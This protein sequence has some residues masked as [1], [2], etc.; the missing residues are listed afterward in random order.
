MDY[1]PK[2]AHRHNFNRELICIEYPG[3]VVNPE[4]MMDTLGGIRDISATFE[5]GRRRLELRFRPE[6]MYAKPVFG[7]AM[8]ASAMALKIVVRRKKTNPEEAEVRSVRIAGAVRKMYKFGTMCDFQQLPA[9]RARDSGKVECVHDEIVPRGACITNRLENPD[10]LPFFLPP[11]CFSRTDTINKN[12]LREQKELKPNQVTKRPGKPRQ[13]HGIYQV[14]TMN[15]PVPSEPTKLCQE[16]LASRLIAKKDFDIIRSAFEA[17][18]I[19][20]K[21]ALRNMKQFNVSNDMMGT[22]LPAVAYF[23]VNGPW[24]STWV[25]FGYDPRKHFEAR[26]YQMLDFRVR[27]SD[28]HHDTIK[29]KRL[30]ISKSNYRFGVVAPVKSEKAANSSIFDEDT[31][32]PC[33]IV[34]YQYCDIHLKKIKDMLSK[35]PTPMSGTVCDERHGW[36]PSRFDDQCRNIMSE[37][38]ARNIRKRSATASESQSEVDSVY[39]EEGETTTE[40]EGNEQ[41]ESGSE[42]SAYVSDELIPE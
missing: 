29:I 15:E 35:V 16:M 33:R 11:A 4:R 23:Y 2:N 38:V 18:P 19:W 41:D 32:P 5:Q 22:L 7:D 42:G 8:N 27:S 39:G 17:R 21:H 31:I 13:K 37:I 14:F 26:M 28:A 34:F 12:V 40:Y 24:R 10:E 25:R 6:C 20:T 36:L 30:A 9:F 3:I 1:N